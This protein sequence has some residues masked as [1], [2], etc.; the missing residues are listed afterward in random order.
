MTKFDDDKVA[1]GGV[2][3]NT[4]CGVRPALRLD[5]E[6]VSFR[7]VSLSGGAHSTA[8]GDSSIKNAFFPN[9]AIPEITTIT[10]TADEGYVFPD[11]PAWYTTKGGITVERTSDTVVTVSGTPTGIVNVVI[12]D[13]TYP[14]NPYQS[15]VNTKNKVYF[16][17]KPWI[18][19]KDESTSSTEGILTLLAGDESFGVRVFDGASTM[20]NRYSTSAIKAYLDGLTEAGGEM[21]DV[22]G[23]IKTTTLTTYNDDDVNAKLYLL[24]S[25]EASVLPKSAL[26]AEF[27]SSGWSYMLHSEWW[28]RSPAGNSTQRAMYVS[29]EY[30]S[31]GS[32]G[33]YVSEEYGIRPALQIDLSLATFADVNLSGGENSTASGDSSLPQNT[34]FPKTSV[35]EILVTY[36][37]NEGYKFPESSDLY[38]TTDGI[39][40]EKI[41]D[42]KVRVSGAPTGIVN[43][44]VPN[45]EQ[46]ITYPVTYKVVGGTWSD[47]TTANK[48]ETV[49]SGSVPSSVPTGMKPSSGYTG[50]SWDIDPTSATITGAKTFT[51]TFTPMYTVTYKV[52]GGTWSDGTTANKTE[53]VISGSAPSSI[54]TGMKATSGYMG[55]SWDIDPTSATITG[56]KT[57]TYTFTRQP[58]AEVI[59]APT[60]NKSLTF[61]GKAQKLIS[62]GTAKGG[63]LK[64]ALGKDASNVPTKGWSTSIP[65]ATKSGTYY[66]WYKVAG[67]GSYADA[68]AV[69]IKVQ[70]AKNQAKVSGTLRF[71]MT[72]KNKTSLALSWNKVENVDG[73]DIFFSPCNHDGK[74]NKC[75]LVKT[76]K[77]NKTF[78][79]I[80]TKLKQGASYKAYIKAFVLVGGKKKYVRTSPMAHAFAGDSSKNNTNA[81]GV[82]VNKTKL[83][84]AQGKSFSIK[85]KVVG[86]DAKKKIMSEGHVA[87]LR[88]MTS[89]SKVATVDSAGKITARGKGTC[90]IYV[91]AHNGVS[92]EI[93]VAV[94]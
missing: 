22:A 88:Y 10:Y 18:I 77:G 84:L 3:V 56:A 12:P 83:S 90:K 39:T 48:T 33:T 91:Y 71:K 45:A 74:I 65:T 47:G 55:G 42:T 9:G 19:I 32:I 70:I 35:P 54:P 62:A 73:Y 78:S 75:K 79:A 58:A 34:F 82:I 63:T 30:G 64:Y 44:A 49:E 94:K 28:L 57:F 2:A 46:I 61:N 52:V 50:G 20:S 1:S 36:T 11:S 15:I 81:K 6:A 8:S 68:K 27:D 53:S 51:Y 16:G 76:I 86:Q 92:K 43:I 26:E 59:K 13:A 67:D 66:V 24:S 31:L 7:S 5:L 87:S 72:S 4:E 93:D 41:S 69:C 21:A 37:A 85:A 23:A 17:G 29:G 80:K 14:G 38:T 40:V 89:N 25:E 60:A